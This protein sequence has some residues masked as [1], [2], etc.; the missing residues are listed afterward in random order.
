MIEFKSAL[1][2]IQWDL[3]GLSKI[4]KEGAELI[5]RRNGNIILFFWQSKRLQKT[6]FRI[7]SKIMDRVD[8]IKGILER[9]S[10]LKQ[11]RKIIR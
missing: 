11:F 10:T 3:L 2:K 9:N 1:D 7:S 4:R 6:S 8:E 5:K